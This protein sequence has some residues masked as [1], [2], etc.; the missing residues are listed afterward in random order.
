V[1]PGRSLIQIG[2]H[3]NRLVGFRWL[4]VAFIGSLSAVAS[5]N[6]FASR[7]DRTAQ[8]HSAVECLFDVGSHKLRSCFAAITVLSWKYFLSCTSHYRSRLQFV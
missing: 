7:H 8:A 3:Q 5:R 4:F 2:L 6:G 1:S